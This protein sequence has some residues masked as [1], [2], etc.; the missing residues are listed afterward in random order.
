M[1]KTS[2]DIGKDFVAQ[3][4]TGEGPDI[5]ISAPR[6]PGR[7]G[8][9]RRR[10]PHRARRQGRRLLRVRH[11]RRHLRRQDLRHAVS[12]IE[13]IALVRNNALAHGDHRDDVRRAGRRRPRAPAPRSRCSS[14]RVTRPTRTTCTRCRRRSAPRCSSR[15]RTAPTPTRSRLGG[16]AGDAFAAYL[17]K[18]G[19][20]KVLDLVDRRRQGQAGVPRR[21]GAVHDHRPVEHLG[22]QG[23]RHGH[24]RA[25]R[26]ERR[27]P[28]GAAV[29]RRPGRL[30]LREVEEPGP[31]Q[32]VRRRTT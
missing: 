17:A 24:L 2:G 23:G 10:R 25:A 13:N 11:R 15:P 27:R 12:S 1:Q 21:P 22:L 19:Q 3:V 14:S 8:Q 26:P 20:E 4:P 6:R 5:I 28:A 32:R 7:V 18:L 29:R 16:E 31:R 30:H 9:Q